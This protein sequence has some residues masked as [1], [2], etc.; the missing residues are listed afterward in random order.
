[1]THGRRSRRTRGRCCRAQ[2][3]QVHKQ[4]DDW[5]TTVSARPVEFLRSRTLSSSPLRLATPVSAVGCM[6]FEAVSRSSLRCCKVAAC[7]KASYVAGASMT[8][9]STTASRA[10]MF[11]TTTGS[12]YFPYHIVS[13]TQHDQEHEASSGTPSSASSSLALSSACPALLSSAS[14]YSLNRRVEG[15]SAPMRPFLG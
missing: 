10:T 8:T 6:L 9:S 12:A 7:R 13:A 2:R 1:M 4:I 5:H 3:A 15:A 11:P 14:I